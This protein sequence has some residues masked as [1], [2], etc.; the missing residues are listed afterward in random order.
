MPADEDRNG[1]IPLCRDIDQADGA[2]LNRKFCDHRPTTQLEISLAV[3]GVG[4]P[5]GFVVVGLVAPDVPVGAECAS[6]KEFQVRAGA[7]VFDDLVEFVGLS[8]VFAFSR[9]DDVHLTAT[10]SERSH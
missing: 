10:R 2:N 5:V 6:G 8:R 7:A 3:V 1:S 4:W 9:L